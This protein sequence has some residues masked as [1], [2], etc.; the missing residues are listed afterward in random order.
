[1]N[2]ANDEYYFRYSATLRIFG[3]IPDLAELTRRLGVSPTHAHRR[4]DSQGS[5]L[6]L[7]SK[8]HGTI[9]LRYQKRRTFASMSTRFGTRSANGSNFS[10]NSRKS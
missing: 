1:M 8:M 4:G 9:L 2:A 10:F 5:I 3:D 6:P 7:T